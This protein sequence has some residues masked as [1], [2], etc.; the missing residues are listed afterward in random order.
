MSVGFSSDI[1]QRQSYE[2]THVI[3][4]SFADHKDKSFLAIYDGHRGKEASEWLRNYCTRF[5]WEKL[6]KARI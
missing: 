1:G 5:Y 2:D 6:K 3:L 4:K